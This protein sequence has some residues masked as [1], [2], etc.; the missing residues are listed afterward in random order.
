MNRIRSASMRYCLSLVLP[1]FAVCLLAPGL[2]SAQPP[3]PC[4]W[5]GCTAIASL[6]PPTLDLVL[7]C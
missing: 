2:A 4:N 3:P 1:F 7:L 5:P 6:S